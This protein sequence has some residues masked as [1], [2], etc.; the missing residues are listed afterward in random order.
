VALVVETPVVV[1]DEP[2]P[3]PVAVEPEPASVPDTETVSDTAKPKR[4][5]IRK[6][7]DES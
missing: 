4:R 2:S 3:E 7:K 6:K 1:E 5:S